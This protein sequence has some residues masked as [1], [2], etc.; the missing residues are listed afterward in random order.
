MSP[1][2]LDSSVLCSIFTLLST[3][4]DITSRGITVSNQPPQGQP[5]P[6]LWI[7]WTPNGNAST[8]TEKGFTA[9]LT[10]D[11]WTEK[12]GDKEVL[13]VLGIIDD[14]LTTNESSI[15]ADNGQVF[16]LNMVGSPGVTRVASKT[17][18]HGSLI[19]NQFLTS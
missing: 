6:F 7:T 8:K 3:H 5:M 1:P 19:Y 9:A 10:F 15:T 12:H 14:I 18:S 4:A 17:A 13:E 2:L 11:Y 16:C